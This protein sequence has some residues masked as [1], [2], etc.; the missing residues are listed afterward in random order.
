MSLNNGLPK[1]WNTT[2]DEIDIR[3]LISVI[4]YSKNFILSIVFIFLCIGSFYSFCAREVWTSHALINEPSLQQVE[5]L[6]L[7]IEK[8]KS[9]IPLESVGQIDFSTLTRPEIY[10]SFV[11]AFNGM[12]N[13]RSFL[14]KEGIFSEELRQ[15]GIDDTRNDNALMA[16]LGKQ[17]VAKPFDKTSTDI[18]L[19][20]SADSAEQ[21]NK[22][23]LAYIDFTQSQQIVAKNEELKIIIMNRI[24][25]LSVQYENIKSDT[26][27]TQ[28]D[29]IAKTQY[30]LQISVAAG[31]DKPLERVNSEQI[32]NVDLGSK[33]LAE[34]LSILKGIKK[35]ELLN[36]ELAKVRQQLNSLK[37]LK[38]E[39][40]KFSSF[41][42]IDSP[43]EPFTRDKPKRLLIVVLS[44]LLGGVLGV[45]IVLV[46]HAFRRPEEA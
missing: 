31:V 26:L 7:E 15:A 33:G 19:S 2:D 9:S 41:Y 36:P 37:S 35:P 14:I 34:K 11:T 8:L 16:E 23:L 17:I 21:A 3:E 13:K 27:K 25:A 43:A 42:M 6:Q 39:D 38:L 44:A 29:E 4:L 12:N 30:S 46:R 20:F 5:A 45:A 18:S 32:F 24:K 10:K 22:R 40:A 1:T 28:Q